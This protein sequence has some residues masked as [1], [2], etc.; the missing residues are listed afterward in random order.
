MRLHVER[1]DDPHAVDEHAADERQDNVG[2]RVDRVHHLV[3]QLELL[4]LRSPHRQQCRRVV[5]AVVVARH[6]Q[7]RQ[8]QDD[9]A[10]RHDPAGYREWG[11]QIAKAPVAHALGR[12]KVRDARVV[13]SH[14]AA[15]KRSGQSSP[16][17][18]LTGR[19]QPCGTR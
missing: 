9:P 14:H 6:Q 13:C 5:V 12:A 15:G 8:R 16:D 2:Q 4:T 3:V 18:E 11:E 10:G 17:A 7:R 19:Q 1:K